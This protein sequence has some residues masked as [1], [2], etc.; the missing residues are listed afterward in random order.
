VLLDSERF[1]FDV[2][3]SGSAP[4]RSKDNRAREGMPDL[5]GTLEIGPNLNSTLARGTGWKLDLRMPVH[6]VLTLQKHV[7]AIGWTASPVINLD[8]TVAGWNVGLQGGPRWASQRYHAYYYDVDAAYATAT[9]PTYS[10]PGGAAGWRFTVAATRRFGNFWLGGFVRADSLSGAGFEP[11]PLVKRRNDTTF[12]L[13]LSWV[14]KTSD[15]R[16]TSDD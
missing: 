6:G 16:V 3:V 15:E 13:A 5:S 10:A 12:G 14:I 11:S 2:S 9:R 4:T 1:D 8:T 7:R